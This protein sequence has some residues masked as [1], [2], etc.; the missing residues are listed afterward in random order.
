[1]HTRK[2]GEF[3][4][5]TKYKVSVNKFSAI[6]LDMVGSYYAIRCSVKLFTWDS[7]HFLQTWVNSVQNAWERGILAM[8]W[9]RFLS[10]RRA[11]RNNNKMWNYSECLLKFEYRSFS[12][13]Y[14][15][16]FDLTM[17]PIFTIF[18]DTNIKINSNR[19]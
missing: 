6:C 7:S 5:Q 14:M 9:G 1:M 17:F 19:S 3:F 11:D 10:F 4:F 18:K 13:W 15:F 12:I 2:P 16:I 8:F